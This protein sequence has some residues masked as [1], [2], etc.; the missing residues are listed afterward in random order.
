MSLRIVSGISLCLC[1]AAATPARAE[2]IELLRFLE[3]HEARDWPAAEKA[4]QSLETSMEPRPTSVRLKHV[5]VLLHVNKRADARVG[6]EGVL[7]EEP[8]NVVALALL[9]RLRAGESPEAAKTLLLDAAREGYPV[10]REIR[11]AKE[12]A[13]LRDD[14]AF[15]LAA[16][17]A[18]SAF[19]S[20]REKGRNP[21]AAPR[22]SVT[23]PPRMP[24]FRKPT[25]IKK[26]K[27][28]SDYIEQ[29]N[30]KLRSM[31]RNLRAERLAEVSVELLDVKGL[32][33]EMRRESEPDFAATADEIWR[34]AFS[35][36]EQARKLL[37]IK[38]LGI[39]VTGIV[40]APQVPSRTIVALGKDSS[41]RIY[42]E[43][44]ELRDRSGDRIRGLKVVKIS[45]GSV[46][47]DFQGTEFARELRSKP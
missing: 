22:R 7:D 16:M 43:G 46:R 19:D 25:Q 17:R 2:S 37:R 3:A 12:L 15:V 13:V 36:E 9:A 39:V 33:D 29:G 24:N 23:E 31:Q 26:E 6:V 34:R 5:D 44:D 47:F 18:T 11:E 32:C 42:E 27:R 1:V 20:G 10:L 21:F 35:L 45:D 30:E 41:G 38:E 8:R 28:L 40:L 4:W 14:P